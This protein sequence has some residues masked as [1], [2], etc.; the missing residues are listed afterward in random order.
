MAVTHTGITTDDSLKFVADW[1]TTNFPASI[2]FIPSWSMSGDDEGL[3]NQ[4][5]CSRIRLALNQAGYP[6]MRAAALKF[7]FA[8]MVRRKRYSKRPG[9]CLNIEKVS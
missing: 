4:S 5:F 3:E 2:A 1:I 9:C 7:C 6:Q 8:S